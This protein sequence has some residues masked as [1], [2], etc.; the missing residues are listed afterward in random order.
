MK[1]I[2]SPEEFFGHPMG[3]DRKLARWDKLTEYYKA[4]DASSTRVKTVELGKTTEGNPLLMV[5]ITSQEN[6]LNLD[7]I[8]ATGPM[9]A[10]GDL[11]PEEEEELILGGKAV[12]AM[13]MS[14]HATEVGGAQMAPELAYELASGENPEILK[15]LDETVLLLI[16]CMNPDGNLMVV[17]WYNE[18]LGT[19]YE[20]CGVPWLYHKYAGHD[21]NRDLVLMNIPESR[22]MARVLFREWF[23]LAY[24]DY[25]HYGSFGGRY[26]IPPFSNPTDPNV[27]PLLWT[28]MQLYGSAMIVALEQGGRTGVENYA[29]FTAEFNS[30]YTRVCSWHGVTGMLTESAS[31]KLASPKY[32]HY[33]Q[34]QGT[35]GR[36]EYRAHVNFPH[37]WMG[38]WWTLRDI[39]DQ[40][41]ISAYA[42]LDMAAKYRETLLRNLG[43]KRRRAAE[44]GLCEEPFAL[45]VDPKQHDPL[46]ALKLLEALRRSG[47]KVHQASAPFTAEGVTYPSGTYVVPFG[48]IA[49]PYL[50]SVLRRR[51]YHDNPW[52]RSVN[53][54]PLDMQDIAGY[55]LT[56]LMGVKTREAKTPFSYA[57]AEVDEVKYPEVSLP[58][59]EHGYV[60]DPRMND[61]YRLVNALLR[62][63]VEVR[64]V[65]EP[66]QC[67]VT[68]LPPGTFIVPEQPGVSAVL[69]KHAA[70]CH[71]RVLPAPPSVES[72][73]VEAKSA[74]VYQRYWGGNMDEGWTRFLLDGYGFPYATVKDAEVMDGLDDYKVLVIP[75]DPA[76]VITGEKLEEYFEERYKGRM[77]MPKF[78]EQYRSGI[79]EEGVK[80]VKEWVENGGT[81]V[82]LNEA[83]DFAVKALKLPVINVLECK[84]NSEFFCP[85]STLRAV[86][87]TTNP[88]CYG[89]APDTKLLHWKSPAY[90]VK[91]V[92]DNEN[93]SVLA[94]YVDENVMESGWLIGEKLICRKAAA[95]EAKL[96][97]GRVIMYGFWTQ[98]R[99]QSHASFKFLFNTLLGDQQ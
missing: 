24:L 30:A 41:K 1:V 68:C 72:V 80:K 52:A 96:G 82:L 23:P 78:P 85:G 57:A 44:K 56:E 18:W 47:V 84:P 70:E 40:Q 20:G 6:H 69:Q 16:P 39:V 45:I 38:G 73:P 27:D 81:L 99:A 7:K 50:M 11:S 53:G 79:G 91:P 92:E 76:P 67:G 83:G 21:N 75:S 86:I 14:I 13:G 3:E 46:T 94:R 58:L 28:E 55:N 71:V 26:Y 95:I 36:P 61:S 5:I 37:P 43:L 35:R 9:L 25:H 29:G 32:V 62:E 89:V 54:D 65:S 98:F 97:K 31:A 64:R 33:H 34:L 22:H 90:Q 77:A 59:S 10:Y 17:D 66:L 42:A 87:D 15:I 88:L 63:G 60:I 51:H 19:E 8:K 74:A 48:Q 2:P 49:R 93:F 4:L 12:I